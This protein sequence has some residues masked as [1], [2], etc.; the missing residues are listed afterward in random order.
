MIPHNRPTLGLDEQAAVIRV[1]ESGWVAQGPEVVAFEND[2]CRFFDLPNGHAV[3][4]SSGSAALYLALW[5]LGVEISGLAC[6]Y[7]PALRCA[8]RSG[9]S[10]E[11]AYISILGKAAPMLIWMRPLEWVSI[12]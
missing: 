9:L 10:T 5:A 12:S 3:V 8:M 2:L 7:T 1:L 4:V 6:R 11:D